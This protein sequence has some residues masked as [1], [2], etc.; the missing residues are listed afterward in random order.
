MKVLDTLQTR[1]AAHPARIVLSEGHDPRIVAAALRATKAGIASIVLVGP[2]ETVRAEISAQGGQ[3]G[4][5]LTIEDPQSSA[6]TTKLA[7][8]YFDLRKH[9]G[10]TLK[11]AAARACDPLIFSAMMVRLALADGT[12]G[13]AI[14]TTSDTVRA[15]L[16]VIGKAPD[17]KLVS[18]FFLMVLP[19]DHPSGRDAMIFSDCGL[20]IEP[21][22]DELAAIAGQS[23]ES[24]IALLNKTPK[25]AFLSFST[26]GSALHQSVTK[27]A[28]AARIFREDRPDIDSDG[29]L[30]F[31]AAFVPSIGASKSPGSDVAGHAN[32]MIFP[33]LDAGNIGYKIA[34]RIGG[35]TAIGPVLQGLAKPAN[36]LSRGCSADDVVNMIAVSALQAAQQP[37]ID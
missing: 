23:A 5:T 16:Q 22:A 19:E 1:A 37:V 26:K 3:L 8:A 7:E 12:I 14:A 18:S 35:C 10:I 20:V 30:Q 25:V 34:Q 31:D 29:E 21:D 27:V 15:A 4:E 11:E 24:F 17:A 2:T 33:D 28:R 13:G 32:V 9:K 36:D 6:L